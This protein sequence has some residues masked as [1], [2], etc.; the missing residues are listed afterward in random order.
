MQPFAPVSLLQLPARI[1]HHRDVILPAQQPQRVDELGVR[2]A[3]IRRPVEPI[4][5][6]LPLANHGAIPAEKPVLG[7]TRE[8]NSFSGLPTTSVYDKNSSEVR[9]RSLT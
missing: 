3:Q 6:H 8:K 5:R 9:F 2:P 7:K 4:D 1:R